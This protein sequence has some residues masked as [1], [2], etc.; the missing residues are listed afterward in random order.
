[1]AADEVTYGQI[2]QEH[3]LFDLPDNASEVIRVNFPSDIQITEI[4]DATSKK[5]K[6]ASDNNAHTEIK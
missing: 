5:A 3:S 1:M 2:V 4:D 6:Y